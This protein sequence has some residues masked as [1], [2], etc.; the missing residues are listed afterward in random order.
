[1]RKKTHDALKLIEFHTS[2]RNVHLLLEK[3]KQVDELVSNQ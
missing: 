3:E 1:M 2:G